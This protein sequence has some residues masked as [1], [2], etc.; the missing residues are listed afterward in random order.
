MEPMEPDS[1]ADGK[2]P[3]NEPDENS[4]LSGVNSILE[5]VANVIDT[6]K[7]VDAA[8]AWVRCWT[9]NRPSEASFR[10]QYFW[11]SLAFGLLIFAGIGVLGWLGV[12]PKEGTTGL[13]GILIGYWFGQRSKSN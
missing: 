6:E 12:I 5:A 4:Y 13:L 11:G 3:N 7:F 10:V 2:A 8:R 9:E 1:E